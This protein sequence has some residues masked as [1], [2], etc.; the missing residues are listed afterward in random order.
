MD[1][2]QRA[3]FILFE[4]EHESCASIAAGLELPLGTVHSRLHTARKT[5]REIVTRRERA[6]ER[7]A[8][9]TH[10]REQP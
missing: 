5:F 10:K 4:L 8:R 2:G 7:S 9:V 6:S 3:V 1:S